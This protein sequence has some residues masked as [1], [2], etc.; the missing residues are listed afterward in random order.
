MKRLRNI[1]DSGFQLGKIHIVTNDVERKEKLH[2]L[3]KLRFFL[4]ALSIGCIPV[5]FY[6]V[7]MPFLIRPWLSTMI[8]ALIANIFSVWSIKKNMPYQWL[9]TFQF[10]LDML[11]LIILVHY[12]GGLGSPFVP[13]FLLLILVY[14]L[15]LSKKKLLICSIEISLLFSIAVIAEHYGLITQFTLVKIQKTFYT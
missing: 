2:T 5:L 15:F 4:I 10:R 9:V 7:E 14:S 3:V 6:I 1:F 8:V 12:T 11:L 13:M